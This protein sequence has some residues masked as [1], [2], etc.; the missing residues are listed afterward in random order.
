MR[1]R[2]PCPRPT[3]FSAN[4]AQMKSVFEVTREIAPTLARVLWKDADRWLSGQRQRTVNPPTHA[5][6]GGSNP[7]LSTRKTVTSGM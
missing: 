1:G 2:T 4:L 6:Y 3:A 7:P 5:V